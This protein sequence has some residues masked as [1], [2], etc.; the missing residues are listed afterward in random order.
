[1]VFV[2]YVK[3]EK[4]L[5]TFEFLKTFKEVCFTYI[6]LWMRFTSLQELRIDSLGVHM[7]LHRR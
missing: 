3:I 1:M 5:F 7:V 2:F 4:T 6:D